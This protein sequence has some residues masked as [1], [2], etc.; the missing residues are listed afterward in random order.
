M[1][2]LSACHALQLANMRQYGLNGTLNTTGIKA[3]TGAKTG[4]AD[5]SHCIAGTAY[6][7]LAY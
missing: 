5:Y 2:Y 1:L 3:V 6:T 7:Y 4:A